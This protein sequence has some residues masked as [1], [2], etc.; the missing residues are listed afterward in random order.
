ML[1]NKLKADDEFDLDDLD[2]SPNKGKAVVRQTILKEHTYYLEGELE[3]IEQFR[4][5]FSLL[6]SATDQDT[7][8]IYIN[9]NGGSV[10]VG[11][12]I[13]SA[14]K[15]AVTNEIVVKAA[16]GFECASMATAVAL[17]CSD[18][19]VYDYSTFLVHP[20]SGGE[21]GY[22][23]HV[24]KSAEFYAKQSEKMLRRHYTGFLSETELVDLINSPKDLL[25][26]SNEI[27]KRFKASKRVKKSSPKKK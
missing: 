17:A 14:I 18:V 13:V 21:F 9:S 19:V 8:L 25:F 12:A 6:K 5:L 16:I 4:P 7:I 1:N 15:E 22:A 27:A 20:F 3:S 11:E 23:K 24:Q 26:D 10:A 2:L